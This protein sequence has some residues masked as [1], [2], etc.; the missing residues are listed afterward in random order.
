[1]R[2]IIEV[3]ESGAGS[4]PTATVIGGDHGLGR[5][6]S[7]NT[8]GASRAGASNGGPA[9]AGPGAQTS[10]VGAVPAEAPGT[11]PIGGSALSAGAAP[12]G[13]T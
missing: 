7:S 2:I 10:E 13:S 1:M 11:N 9:P 8:S 4:S 3:D 12:S 6:A 5:P